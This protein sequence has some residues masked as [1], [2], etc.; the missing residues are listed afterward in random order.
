MSPYEERYPVN[1]NLIAVFAAS[2]LFI[3]INLVI[4]LNYSMFDVSMWFYMVAIDIIVSYCLFLSI[5]RTW[6]I[7]SIDDQFLKFGYP[8]LIVKISIKNIDKISFITDGYLL[9]RENTIFNQYH[10]NRR[11]YITGC[12]DVM[13]VEYDGEEVF[14]FSIRD[15][16]E[17]GKVLT[18]LLGK[19]KVA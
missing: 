3:F 2:I 7:V 16:E 8:P 9:A 10:G 1:N 5:V 11:S 4:L 19:E 12:Y 18:S 17:A 14:F 6:F 13:K 15:A